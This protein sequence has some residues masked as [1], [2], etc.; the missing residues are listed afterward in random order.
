MPVKTTII[1]S[2]SKQDNV[3]TIPRGDTMSKINLDTNMNAY[4]PSDTMKAIFKEQVDC[5]KNYPT[6]E[7]DKL[8][9]LI[10][11]F[12]KTDFNKQ[13]MESL[14]GNTYFCNGTT[15]AFDFVLRT[16]N[17]Q[18]AAIF[19]P[20]YWG[21]EKLLEQNNYQVNHID[22]LDYFNYDQD[23]INKIASR[24]DI[25]FICSP[26]NPTLSTLDA[27]TIDKLCIT[28]PECH[29]IIDETML[30]F[31]MDFFKKTACYLTKKHSNLT[32]LISF[33]KIF[34]LGGLRCGAIVSN[35]ENIKLINKIRIPYSTPSITQTIIEL[36]LRDKETLLNSLI[37][38]DNNQTELVKQLKPYCNNIIAKN[39]N[40]ILCNFKENQN[41]QL[42]AF[43]KEHDIII[44]DLS[45]TYL[46]LKK[47]YLRITIGTKQEC[48]IL[49]NLVKQYYEGVLQ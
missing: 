21:Y 8:D 16:L 41:I 4:Y 12:L 13:E 3:Y 7:N 9:E 27:D 26:N 47:D 34:A 10:S 36:A 38:I 37:K 42:F 43:L 39:A 18:K 48:Q 2:A 25:I 6:Y 35:Q 28:N 15:E 20:T 19:K 40:F 29:F 22:N 24:H 44:R 30:I 23:H 17:K 45:D 33:S 49:V 1:F 46:E 5:I 32:I 31:D 14:K 11:I